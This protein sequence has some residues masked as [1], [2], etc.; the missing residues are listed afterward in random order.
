MKYSSIIMSKEH[1]KIEMMI[2]MAKSGCLFIAFIRILQAI[3]ESFCLIIYW[4]IPKLSVFCPARLAHSAHFWDSPTGSVISG[5]K[6][7][8]KLFIF[9]LWIVNLF[10]FLILYIN[11]LESFFIW[12]MTK[13]LLTSRMKDENDIG[14]I[15]TV[16][17]RVAPIACNQSSQYLTPVGKRDYQ[18]Q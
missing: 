6:I 15:D 11:F 18:K 1:L 9:I 4:I 17:S 10:H 7:K 12:N 8:T 16:H 14:G 5:A 2:M 3:K 13:K